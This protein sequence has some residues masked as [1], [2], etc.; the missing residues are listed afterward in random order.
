MPLC[1]CLRRC[2]T[3]F[4][5]LTTRMLSSF[6]FLEECECLVSFGVCLLVLYSGFCCARPKDFCWRFESF[7]PATPFCIR[8]LKTTETSAVVRR[9]GMEEVPFGQ[10]SHAR[11]TAGHTAVLRHEEGTRRTKST[12]SGSPQIKVPPKVEFEPHTWSEK[13]PK[14]FCKESSYDSS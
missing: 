12:K 11:S 5:Y 7:W 2:V 1:S 8:N 13:L 14:Y 10:A 9:K 3:S 6:S 4:C